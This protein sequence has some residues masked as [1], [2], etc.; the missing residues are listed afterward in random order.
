MENTNL[1]E[2]YDLL[3]NKET[4]TEI[5]SVDGTSLTEFVKLY[6]DTAR[7]MTDLC[8]M[9]SKLAKV[10]RKTFKEYVTTNLALSPATVSVMIKAGDIYNN[11]VEL[12]E[13]NYTKVYELQPVNEQLDEFIETVGGYEALKPMSQSDIRN[14]VK[15]F[16][17][18]ADEENGMI[19]NTEETEDENKTEDTEEQ[20]P[21]LIDH[22]LLDG[23]QFTADYIGGLSEGD[24]LDADDIQSFKYIIKTITTIIKGVK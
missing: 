6:N 11:H 3:S 12:L 9:A 14:N 16:L 21:D 23:L 17:R 19:D 8:V 22:S 15:N 1:N 18:E 13:M 20:T 5:V 10:D 2:T 7:T 24:E 4:T